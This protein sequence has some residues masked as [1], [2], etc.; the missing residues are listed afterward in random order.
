MT[1][2]FGLIAAT[3][4]FCWGVWDYFHSEHRSSTAFVKAV[5]GLGVIGVLAV[6][7]VV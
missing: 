3:G 7:A 5:I 6:R 1:T 2:T 4:V